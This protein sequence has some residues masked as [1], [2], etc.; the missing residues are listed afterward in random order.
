MAASKVT[1]PTGTAPGYWNT[2]EGRKRLQAETVKTEA[3]TAQVQAQVKSLQDGDARDAAKHLS[4]MKLLGSAIQ[5]AADQAS[6]SHLI[7]VREDRHEAQLLA[8]DRY[9][10]V[11]SFTQQVGPSSVRECV[12]MLTEWVRRSESLAEKPPI[13]VIFDS[14]GGSVIDG[15][16]LWDFLSYVKS[17][18]HHLTTVAFGMA[19][20]MAGIL[21]QAGDTR[22]LG[23]E[24]YLLIHEV[25]FGAGGKIGEVEDEVKFVRK[26]QSRVLDIFAENCADALIARG[27]RKLENRETVV[28]ER[29]GKIDRCWKRTDWWLDSKECLEFGLVDEVR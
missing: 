17:Q 24:S 25:S 9:N 4:E 16:H 29:R 15:M 5:T 20:S 10:F 7:A 13:T 18:G 27:D 2:P 14:P 3:E 28:K 21:L 23:R 11:Y 6:V 26:I 8:D 12:N 19:A 22:V 1:D